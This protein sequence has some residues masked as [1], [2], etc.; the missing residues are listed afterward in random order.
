MF[1]HPVSASLSRWRSCAGH[2]LR[3]QSSS[4]ILPPG[5]HSAL[6]FKRDIIGSRG[7]SE[8]CSAA[9]SS[10]MGGDSAHPPAQRPAVGPACL[11]LQAFLAYVVL[12]WLKLSSIVSLTQGIVVW[13]NIPF[14]CLCVQEIQD[15][16]L[17]VQVNDSHQKSPCNLCWSVYSGSSV[18]HA[19]SLQDK[20]KGWKF[21][22]P[23]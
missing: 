8:L 9:G 1:L 23:I 14:L 2:K 18:R 3:T 16:Q 19:E 13:R 15:G 11:H 22:Q 17:S 10:D 4:W 21:A 20:I 5:A 6:V 7:P 12:C